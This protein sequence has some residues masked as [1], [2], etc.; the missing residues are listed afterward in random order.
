M[1]G[2]DSEDIGS[3]S[4]L[5]GCKNW[6]PLQRHSRFR[7]VRTRRRPVILSYLFR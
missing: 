6:F 4:E 5:R 1:Y 7:E 3:G 2:S